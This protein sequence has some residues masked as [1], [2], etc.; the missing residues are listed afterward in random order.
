MEKLKFTRDIAQLAVLQ[1]IELANQFLMRI[2][3]LFGRYL[4]SKIFSKYLIDTIKVSGKY[5]KLI[6]DEYE[7]IKGFLVDGQQI[8]SI[9]G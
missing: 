5:S 3:K 1:R 7:N 2:R 6:N 8:L 4:F 9:G